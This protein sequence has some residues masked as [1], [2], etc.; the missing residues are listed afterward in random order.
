[1]SRSEPNYNILALKALWL[2]GESQA[3]R[4]MVQCYQRSRGL[5]TRTAVPK[6]GE[7]F[8]VQEK[9]AYAKF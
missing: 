4:Q 3:S 1:M 9:A 5:G 8:R 2:R 7:G 6:P